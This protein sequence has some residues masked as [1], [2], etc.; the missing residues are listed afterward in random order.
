MDKKAD[1]T[2][3]V[4]MLVE[5]ILRWC[6]TKNRDKRFGEKPKLCRKLYT[7]TNVSDSCRHF[8]VHDPIMKG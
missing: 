5:L 4:L 3:K 7:Q 8:P 6:K 2:T 1:N